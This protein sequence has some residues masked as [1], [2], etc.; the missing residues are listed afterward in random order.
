MS[1]PT[2]LQDVLPLVRQ[3]APESYAESWD[4]VGLQ[5]GDLRWPV[6]TALLCIDLTPAVLAEAHSLQ[7]G[8]IVTYHPLLFEPLI[9]ITSQHWKQ[10][11]VLQCIAS[12]CAVYSPHTALDAAAGGINDWLCEAALPGVLAAVSSEA[13]H[14]ATAKGGQ[15]R[16]IRKLSPVTKAQPY[17]LVTFVPAEHLDALRTALCDAGAGRIGGYTECSFTIEGQGTFRGGE[18]TNP[19]I[20][21]RGKLERVAEQRMEIIVPADRL[22]QVV[23]ALMK[24]HPYEEPAFDLIRLEL[25]PSLGGEGVGQG[26]VVQLDTPMTLDDFTRRLKAQLGAE[27]LELAVPAGRSTVQRV[28]FCAGA[29]G[30][31][32][33]DAGEIDTFVTGEMRHHE[34]LDAL[35][36][37][38]T[39]IL[40]GHTQTERPYLQVYRDRLSRVLPGIQWHVS[41]SDRPPLSRV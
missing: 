9:A 31:L 10:N 7:A 37:G 16:P 22:S 3:L 20:G 41:V 24:Q 34:V 11:L 33:K 21:S 25:P 38:I 6:S 1:T 26:R 40:A 17:K 13:P 23:S 32:L 2:L 27:S 39:V 5:L 15:V 18:G 36:R 14:G 28:G 30:S 8:L 35:Q 19:V 29:G 12:R 4:K